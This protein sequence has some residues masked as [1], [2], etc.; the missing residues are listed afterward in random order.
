MPHTYSS[1]AALLNAVCFLITLATGAALIF[2]ARA[3]AASS[4]AP[5]ITPSTVTVR[6][7]VDITLPASHG[8]TIAQAS[9][10]QACDALWN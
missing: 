9:G 4:P 8:I 10:S 2:H 3:S 7:I 5:F 6:P 1:V